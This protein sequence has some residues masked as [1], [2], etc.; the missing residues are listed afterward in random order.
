MRFEYDRQLMHA[1]MTSGGKAILK[2]ARGLS[3]LMPAMVGAMAGIVVVALAILSER[4]LGY[5]LDLIALS[6]GLVI[7]VLVLSLMVRHSQRTLSR[8]VL[9]TPA[10]IGEVEMQLSPEGVL[11]SNEQ[12]ETAIRWSC[13]DEVLE[14]ETGLGLLAGATV[15]PL[16][17]SALPIGTDRAELR[18]RIA[19]WRHE[20]GAT[21]G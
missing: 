2:R 6:V 20:E 5:R 21:K 10:H 12:T 7:G 16:P 17:D 3:R 4:F 15:L 19:V 14:L 13:I 8:L 11:L 9:E 1:A 18:A